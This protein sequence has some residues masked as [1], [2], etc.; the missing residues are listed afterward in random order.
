MNDRVE[1]L[2]RIN[3]ASLSATRNAAAMSGNL[4]LADDCHAAM[5]RRSVMQTPEIE[6]SGQLFEHVEQP[7][8]ANGGRFITRYTGDIMSWM[9]HSMSDG[10]VA[11]LDRGMINRAKHGGAVEKVFVPIG[12]RAVLVDI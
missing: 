1:T 3:M 11:K 5:Q 6:N 7:S 4:S 9:Q 10:T 8:P 12:K 2:A